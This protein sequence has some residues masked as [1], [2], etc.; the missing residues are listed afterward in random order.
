[1]DPHSAIAYEVAKQ[2]EGVVVSLATASPY[3]FSQD[4]MASLQKE[5][6]DEWQAMADLEK[7]CQDVTPAPLKRLKTQPIL[8][9]SVIEVADMK[10]VVKEELV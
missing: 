1:M 10:A 9:T 2:E 7:V 6:T 5:E 3:K 8:H 4:V